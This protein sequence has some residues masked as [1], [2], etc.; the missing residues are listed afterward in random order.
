MLFILFC[1]L[2][3]V[4][5]MED[6]KDEF[7]LILAGYQKE[8][9]KFLQTNPGLHSRFPIH[10]NFP[11]YN[12]QELLEIAEQLCVTRQYQLT[13]QAKIALLT[14]LN[15]PANN[16]DDNFG[17]ART[18]RNIIEK[19]IR[20]Q[21]VRLISKHSTTREELMVIEPSDLMGV[22]PCGNV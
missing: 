11:D 7:I 21:A 17:N 3:F 1:I 16:S 14:L 8:M 20:R 13:S 6:H 2:G 22:G 10:L 18:V 5:A 19:S 4:K 15:P 12:K 9:E